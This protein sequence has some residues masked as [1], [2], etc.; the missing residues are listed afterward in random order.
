MC[1]CVC[2]CVCVYVS[3]CCV[4]VCVCMYL[5][6][7][8]YVC[9]RV[10][11][12]VHVGELR[13]LLDKIASCTDDEAERDRRLEPLQEV[14][15]LVQF[16]NDECDYGMGLELGLDLFSHGCPTLHSMVRHLL[17]LAYELLQ[18]EAF[19]QVIREH[20][21]HRNTTPLDLMD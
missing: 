8:S 5:C 21:K 16:A 17:P 13:R 1:M 2:V 4:C 9:V 10:C 14:V 7:C 3:L 18:R 11:I 6:V 15:T 19:A 12:H 20:L